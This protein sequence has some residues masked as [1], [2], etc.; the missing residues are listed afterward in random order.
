MGNVKDS[1][2]TLLV[3]FVACAGVAGTLR[4]QSHLMRFTG[5]EIRKDAD[6][7][8]TTINPGLKKIGCLRPRSVAEVGAANWTI[9]GAPV[10]RDFVDF[11][12]Y[13]DYLPPL[14]VSKIRI[15]SGW[16]KCEK[17]RGT[18]D[19]AW[20]DHIVDWCQAHGI[21][22]VLELSYGN[23]IYPG[24]GGAGLKDGIPRSDEGLQA[25]DRWVE[26]LAGHFKGRVREWAMWNE[27]DIN[28]T[29]DNTPEKIAAFNVRSA[30]ILRRHMPDCRIH[31][32]SL[33]SNNAEKLA[34]HL[35]PMGEDVR[36]FDT[37]VYH[38][39]AM[40][41]DTSYAIVE[42]QKQVLAELAPHAKLRQGENGCASEW[43]DRFALRNHAW[44]EVSQA[45]WDMRRMLGDLGHEVESGLFCFVDINYQPPTFPVFYCN[46]KGYLRLNASND[47]IRVKR[48]YY[49]VQNTVSAFDGSVR[50][51]KEGAKARCPDRTISLYEYR[52]G[53]G[54]P[55][56][57]FWQH[58]PVEVVS[59]SGAT[60]LSN[61]TVEVNLDPKAAP[62]DSFETRGITIDWQGAP[63]EDPVWVDLMTG[64]VFEFPADRQ[65]VHSCGVDFVEIPS[66]DSPCV[67]T[68]RK[69]LSLM[70]G[71]RGTGSRSVGELQ[72]EWRTVELPE[73]EFVKIFV[74]AGQSNMAGRG[75]VTADVTTDRIVKF[76]LDGSA[77]EGT[78]PFHA[79]KRV[80]GA[81]LALSFARAYA[82]A[83]PDITVALLPCAVGG[84]DI[85]RWNPECGD[86]YRRMLE[87]VGRV[88]DKGEIVGILWHQGEANAHAKEQIDA[89]EG[90]LREVVL[91]M[92]RNIAD[93][94]VVMGELGEYLADYG[95]LPHWAGINGIIRKVAA[96]IPCCAS[97]SS[98]GL[99]P[100]KD[101]LHFNT[102][103]LREFGRRYYSAWK[104]CAEGAAGR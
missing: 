84:S 19:V 83:H 99:M 40:N 69:A 7:N 63:L 76:A 103:S 72:K 95:K 46:R 87:A 3:L 17:V 31:G 10:D 45:K 41:P 90:Q 21:E 42:K 16:A 6:R 91:A 66:Y 43:L 33:A 35:R 28:H 92:K 44:S 96:D 55:L 39:Y 4:G 15:F 12:K 30:K 18:I 1:I 49:A 98:K 93:V 37:F 64:W 22:V 101:N 9:D 81:G 77:Y 53:N 57:V 73:K 8:A 59:K 26:F 14:G 2:L 71:I 85:K 82:D 24:A 20:L 52:T 11:D 36:L 75:V 79:D 13:C 78:E 94:P 38:G 104:A 67:L 97:V 48:A 47:V 27:P 102:P 58:G 86:L 68:E 88:R 89:Y 5:P 54:S 51:A 34:A 56:L 25:W 80:A 23:P 50:L 74:L 65:I 32:L 70:D 100:N 29:S 60:F 61:G 62:G